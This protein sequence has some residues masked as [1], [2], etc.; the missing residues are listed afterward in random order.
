[1]PV[2]AWLFVQAKKL[3]SNARHTVRPPMLLR[4]TSS[5]LGASVMYKGL[6]RPLC[7][8]TETCR[9][10]QEMP[11]L[12]CKSALCTE[13]HSQWQQW[14]YALLIWP[15]KEVPVILVRQ[16]MPSPGPPNDGELHRG[17]Q[18]ETIEPCTHSRPL[19]TSCEETFTRRI[20]SDPVEMIQSPV[21]GCT[22]RP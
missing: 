20:S 11:S 13:L 9:R 10:A 19:R 21:R 17:A 1:M 16:I 18:Y 2:L 6:L 5:P 15:S 22:T 7:W 3:Q 14:D 4:M 12:A 8:M